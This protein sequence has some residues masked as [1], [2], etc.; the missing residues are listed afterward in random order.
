M[1][2]CDAVIVNNSPDTF[3]NQPPQ[4]SQSEPP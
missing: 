4:C 3:C 1:D 2:L